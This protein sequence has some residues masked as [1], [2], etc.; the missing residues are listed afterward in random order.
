MKKKYFGVRFAISALLLIES[1]NKSLHEGIKNYN[2]NLCDSSFYQKQCL[3]EHFEKYHITYKRD[4]K[5]H[6]GL[7]P[8]NCNECNSGCW[9][10]HD[11]LQ[12]FVNDHEGK[13]KLDQKIEQSKE[14]TIT[15][16]NGKFNLE[17][18]QMKVNIV[19]SQM[20][21]Q[22]NQKSHSKDLKK[23]HPDQN[24]DKFKQYQDKQDQTIDQFEQKINDSKQFD[25][26]TE[27]F[28]QRHMKSVSKD[29]SSV[30][31]DK[32]SDSTIEIHERKNPWPFTM[33][34]KS[35]ILQSNLMAHM[36]T[37]HDRVN[38]L[39]LIKQ[40]LNNVTNIDEAI[41][42]QA[43]KKQIDAVH[44]EKKLSN[45]SIKKQTKIV[46]EEKKL[47]KCSICKFSSELAIDLKRH[48][49]VVKSWR[50]KAIQLCNL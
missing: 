26:V 1:H 4:L 19:S 20:K 6:E 10:K 47:F 42:D 27:Q 38:L 45:T 12:H 28:N 49:Y 24:N 8:F 46:H 22:L 37:Q 33:C 41:P 39:G 5:D 15:L 18:D 48:A 11:L 36:D 3:F 32:K 7:M 30:N 34:N 2:C 13:E 25:T 35:F 17:K 31:V 29:I 43:I 21:D 40:A 16:G 14:G 50:A 23:D 44:E 9:K